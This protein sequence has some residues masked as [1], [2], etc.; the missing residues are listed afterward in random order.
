[1]DSFGK[2]H[3]TQLDR[4]IP[5][6]FPPT[7]TV[8]G[9]SEW[10]HLSLS[11]EPIYTSLRN[12]MFHEASSLIDFGP[13]KPLVAEAE[14]RKIVK[15][16]KRRVLIDVGAN[17]FFASPKYLLDS[18]LPYMPFTHAVMI[19]PEPHFSSSVP[20]VYSET[21]NISFLQIYSEVKIAIILFLKSTSIFLSR[22]LCFLFAL[23]VVINV[24]PVDCASVCLIGWL[25]TARSAL[26]P[27]LIC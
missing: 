7:F 17:G 18:Y 10:K 3:N 6:A 13:Y 23:C 22:I 25:T 11:F 14:V 15:Q 9:K 1:M 4:H 8:A 19:E 26:V 27:K 12:W 20:A 16:K 2:I 5:T 24:R 21:Y